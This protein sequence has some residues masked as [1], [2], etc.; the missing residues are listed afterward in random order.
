MTTGPGETVFQFAGAT[1]FVVD[2]KVNPVEFV[3]QEMTTLVP[4]LEIANCGNGCVVN[5]QTGLSVIA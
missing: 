4:F 2:C 5:A 3:A 1:R